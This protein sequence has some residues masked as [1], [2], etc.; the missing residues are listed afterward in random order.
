MQIV[1]EENI[2]IDDLGFPWWLHPSE[3]YEKNI[4]NKS[5]GEYTSSDRSDLSRSLKRL[6]KSGLDYPQ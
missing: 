4:E 2:K 6:E 1:N 5:S 3:F